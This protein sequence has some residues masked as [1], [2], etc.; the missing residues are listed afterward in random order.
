MVDIAESASGVSVYYHLLISALPLGMPPPA[1]NGTLEIQLIPQSNNVRACYQGDDY[2]SM[3][4]Y[5]DRADGTF[6][7]ARWKESGM[8]AG[9]LFPP[10][11][12]RTRCSS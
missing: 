11:R 10:F 1:I 3:E 6:D 9:A 2:P 12:N 8:G 5:Q 7:V 4:V